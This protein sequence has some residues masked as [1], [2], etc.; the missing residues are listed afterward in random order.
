MEE[1]AR[2]IE[3]ELRENLDLLQNQI[4]DVR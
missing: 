1:H 4:Q 3:R 2:E